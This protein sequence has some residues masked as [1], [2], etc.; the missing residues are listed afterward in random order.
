MTYV[1]TKNGDQIDKYPYSFEQLK[2]DN[3]Q[4]SYPSEV[5]D[6]WLEVQG[7]CK[8][9]KTFPPVHLAD[10]DH[11]LEE[12][13]PTFDQ[14][15]NKWV[16]TWNIILKPTATKEQL[17]QFAKDTRYQWE[18]KGYNFYGTHIATDRESQ[19]K[20]TGARVAA[21]ANPA[22]YTVW[23]SADGST[24]MIDAATMIMISDVVEA[25]VNN[26]FRIYGGIKADIDNGLIT[27][28]QQIADSFEEAISALS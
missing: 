26:C 23:D 12:G 5:D 21:N 6:N 7:I 8:V 17:I 3:P 16:Q 22:W 11:Q 28:F 4:I 24:H 19:V 15:N 27:R 1:L 25:Y 18:T 9:H 13:I 10:N 20:I 14:P 2:A